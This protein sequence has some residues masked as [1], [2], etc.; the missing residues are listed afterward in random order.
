MWRLKIVA[1]GLLWSDDL[2]LRFLDLRRIGQDPEGVVFRPLIRDNFNRFE[3]ALFPREGGGLSG[4][5]RGPCQLMF[6]DSDHLN[7]FS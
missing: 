1:E 7:F 6:A 3:S 4:R 5:E 2:D